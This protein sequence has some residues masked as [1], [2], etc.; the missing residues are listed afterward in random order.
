[1]QIN[2][3]YK[4]TV[5]D[6]LWNVL[7]QLM[8][9]ELLYSFRLVGGTALS[10]QLGH[11]MSVDIDLFTDTEYDSLDFNAIDKKLKELFP[12]VEM[13]YEGNSAFG[14]SY[15]IGNSKNDLVKVD[16]FYTD[17][18]IRPAI[19]I[20]NIRLATLEEIAAMKMEVIGQNGRKKDFWDIHELVERISLDKIITLYTERYPYSYTKEELEKKLIDFNY[21]DSDFTPICLKGKYWELIKEDIEELKNNLSV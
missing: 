1:M 8:N 14:K 10:L 4:E 6:T 16:L 7:C 3:L 9:I 20:E 5:S 11:R 18:F 19:E 17:T 15:Y 2:K 13:Q 21:A 12:F